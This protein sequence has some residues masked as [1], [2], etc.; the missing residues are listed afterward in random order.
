MVA[1]GAAEIADQIQAKI[2][3][4]GVGGVIIN[5]PNGHTPGVISAVAEAVRPLLGL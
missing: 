3:D 4:V 2:L 5:L 1:G